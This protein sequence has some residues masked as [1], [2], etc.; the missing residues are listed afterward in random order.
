MRAYE[1]EHAHSYEHSHHVFD[2]K[3]ASLFQS[4]TTAATIGVFVGLVGVAL[5]V[6]WFYG[7]TSWSVTATVDG[8]VQMLIV[9]VL[10]TI[11]LEQRRKQ[12]IRRTLELAFLNHHV[13]NALTQ[14]TMVSYIADPEKQ[15]HLL[16][17]AASR[18]SEVLFR[19]ANSADLTG[20][21]LEVDLAGVELAHAGE[22][23]ELGEEKKAS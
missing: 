21:S 11:V 5:N 20:L 12:A 3:S 14:M 10:G 17:D 9:T 7:Q 1:H 16:Q 2:F 19:I 23:R 6:V 13:R 4:L 8:L 22:A 18:V 15:E